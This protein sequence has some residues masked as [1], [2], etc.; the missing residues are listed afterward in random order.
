LTAIGGTAPY[1]WSVSAGSLPTGLSLAPATGVIS[2]TPTVA[3]TSNFTIRVTDS[4]GATA[5]RA[6][7]LAIDAAPTTSVQSVAT[8]AVLYEG[9]TS[10]NAQDNLIGV[11]WKGQAFTPS[12]THTV[13]KIRLPLLIASASS[14]SVTV[15]IRKTDANGLPTGSDIATGSIPCSSLSSSWGQKWYDIGLGSGCQLVA[16]TKYALI[17]RAPSVTA[18]I[19][20]WVNTA[21][22]YSR[23]EV[24][25][26]YNSGTTWAK[27]GSYTGWDTA[28]EEWG[29]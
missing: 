28:F 1:N 23:G 26:S 3:A 5:T 7:S 27:G 9:Y 17:V 20:Y 22:T 29:N 21:G 4:V 12:I 10:S 13:T 8:T 11:S 2:G 18:S 16:G 15:S 24:I 6:L 14:G 19:Y 25:Y